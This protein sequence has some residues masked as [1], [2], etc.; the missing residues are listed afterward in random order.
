MPPWVAAAAWRLW[1]Q[2]CWLET[3]DLPQLGLG[4]LEAV[5]QEGVRVVRPVP[6]FW[7]WLAWLLARRAPRSGSAGLVFQLGC[8]PVE[9]SQV[10]CCGRWRSPAISSGLR[11]SLGPVCPVAAGRGCRQ[12]EHQP[13]LCLHRCAGSVNRQ[14]VPRREQSRSGCDRAA[15]ALLLREMCPRHPPSRWVLALAAALALGSVVAP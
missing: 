10:V 6:A 14:R 3:G 4:A 12:L 5:L 9:G 2:S 11:A 15:G 1:A 13:C 8:G 7:C